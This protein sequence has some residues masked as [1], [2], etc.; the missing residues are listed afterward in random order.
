M[1]LKITHLNYLEI[2][3]F[4]FQN[5]YKRNSTHQ[6]FSFYI[7]ITYTNPNQQVNEVIKW[8]YYRLKTLQN[9]CRFR[10]RATEKVEN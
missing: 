5:I 9:T 10:E 3:I 6:Y 1:K 2:G 4:H 7:Q 8:E